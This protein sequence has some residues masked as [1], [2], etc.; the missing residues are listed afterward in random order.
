MRNAIRLAIVLGIA[1]LFPK[2][3][4]AALPDLEKGVLQ[5]NE[6]AAKGATAEAVA[7]YENLVS[8]YPY[9]SDLN[10]NL[11]TVALMANDI[12]KAIL[13]LER[14]LWIDPDCEDCRH[15]LEKAKSL[16]QD[17]VINAPADPNQSALSLDSF[18]LS[19]HESKTAKTFLVFWVLLF[20]GFLS[21]RYFS[22]DRIRFTLGL[23]SLF[24]ALG[25][26]ST[27]GLLLLKNHLAEIPVHAVILSPEATVRQG[28]NMNFPEAFTLHAGTK[29][30]LGETLDDWHQIILDNGLNGYLQ[31]HH[32]R[33]IELE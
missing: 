26:A 4:T 7:L 17:K 33:K 29:V 10:Y 25:A 3:S 28:P 8:E 31:S 27:G 32:F 19:I 21:R 24:L 22:S 6:R 12:G 13:H 18:V 20:A 16:Q 2:A 23:I 9:S 11:G 14:A 5:A 30:K 1:F 15:N